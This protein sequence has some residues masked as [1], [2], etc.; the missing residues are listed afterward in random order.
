MENVSL[1]FTTASVSITAALYWK[2]KFLTVLFM[3]SRSIERGAAIAAPLLFSVVFTCITACSGKKITPVA[4]CTE[5]HGQL[6]PLKTV[7]GDT[8]RLFLDSALVIGVQTPVDYAE[9]ANAL[10]VFDGYN[11]RLLEYPFSNSS[12]ALQ[13]RHVQRI[14]LDQKITY[15]KYL[16]RDSVLLYAYGAFKLYCYSMNR[17]SVY[18]SWSFIRNGLRPS[19]AFNPAPP[20]AGNAAP[21]I[22]RK[23]DIIGTGYLIGEHDDDVPSGRTICSV[24]HLADSRVD[25]KIPYS[26]VYQTGNWGGVHMRTPYVAYNDEERK[27]LVSLPADH[28]LQV[29]DS[30]WSIKN[31]YAGTRE[32]QCITAT[33]L[34]KSDKK[35]EDPDE[36]LRYFTAIP[37]YRNIIY[38]KYHQRY[39]RILQLPPPE[40]ELDEERIGEK[41]AKMIA[42]DKDHRYLG[43][44]QLPRGL[45]LDNFFV[46][47]RGVYFLN[48]T[49]H[50]Q[51]TA[52]YVQVK[53]L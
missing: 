14:G 44:A 38:D 46:T 1:K 3:Y 53:I 6:I 41:R 12:A 52:Q 50:D 13:P 42:F 8:L 30:A 39:Y 24:I 47:D 10:L 5:D 36:A 7:I 48:A 27:L 23:N 21:I 28:Y 25:H 51:N 31:V 49:N 43:E 22:F 20:N 15:L 32:Q 17:D 2:A 29:I 33:A 35:M 4:S 40:E 9:Q 34:A 19:H 11:K 37:S 45:V 16:S 18:R 26:K